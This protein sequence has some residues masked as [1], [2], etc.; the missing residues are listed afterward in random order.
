MNH[1]CPKCGTVIK[2]QLKFCPECGTAQ[3]TVK[4]KPPKTGNEK[5]IPQKPA[6][7]EGKNILYMVALVSIIIV[8]FYGYQYVAPP[9]PENLHGGETEQTA[10]PRQNTFN[11]EEF[12][13]LQEHVNENPEGF[14][15]NVSLANFLFD[16]QQYEEALKYYVKALEVNPGAPDVLVD[17]GVSCFNLNQFENARDYFDRALAL[18]SEHINALYNRGVVAARLGSMEAMQQYWQ[19]LITVAPESQQAQMARQMI[20][21]IKNN[22]TSTP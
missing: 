17:A 1:K 13:H 22:G 15:E 4:K 7:A 14:S 19:R 12:Q 11:Q 18:N 8:G 5:T 20:D 6:R 9:A 16:N 3:K 10:A 2:E 21:Q